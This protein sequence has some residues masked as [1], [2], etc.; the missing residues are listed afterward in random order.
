MV[1]TA[2]RWRFAAAAAAAL[3]LA[4]GGC[5]AGVRDAGED[6]SYVGRFTGEYVDGKPL[7]RLPT[8]YVVGHRGA[9]HL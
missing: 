4:L 6:G 9:D 7:Y 5:A 3:V 2:A 1:R 8:L